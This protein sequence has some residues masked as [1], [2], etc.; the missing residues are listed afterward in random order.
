MIIL[1]YIDVIL[2]IYTG[3]YMLY[4]IVTKADP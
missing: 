4:F 1:F 2:E 3:K